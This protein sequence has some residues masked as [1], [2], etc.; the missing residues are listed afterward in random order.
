MKNNIL[1]SVFASIPGLFADMPAQHQK[2]QE[3]NKEAYVQKSADG[4]TLT[5]YF[6]SWRSTRAGTLYDL[7]AMQT[8]KGCS[9]PAWT[10]TH[11]SPDETITRAVFD[12]S[13]KNFRPTTTRQWFSCCHGLK[14]IIGMENLNTQDVTDM[15][16]MFYD[17]KRLEALD[18][19]RFNTASV[20]NMANMFFGCKSLTCLNLNGFRTDRVTNMRYMFAACTALR[21]LDLSAFHTDHVT[22]MSGMFFGCSALKYVNMQAF[23][24]SKTTAINYM[25]FNC[26]ALTTIY[27][28]NCWTNG[29][30]AHSSST[31]LYCKKLKG[32]AAYTDGNTG[33]G[34]ANPATGYFTRTPQ[35]A[36]SRRQAHL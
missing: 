36:A 20:T 33:I 19:S 30:A 23:S 15:A 3:L 5:F 7:S 25:F 29:P 27:C 12:A 35:A 21:S 13:F 17:C 4:K 32:A 6:D 16:N 11:T 10:G 24:I 9:F 26:K 31:F 18:V 1:Q 14:E 28:D 22:N 8:D 34:M 2:V